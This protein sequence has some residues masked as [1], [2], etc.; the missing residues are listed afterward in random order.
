MH[1]KMKRLRQRIRRS[2]SKYI[3]LGG[4][5]SEQRMSPIYDNNH[6]WHGEWTEADLGRQSKGV[7]IKQTPL[8]K[9]KFA[10]VW[11]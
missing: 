9:P 8:S 6:R 2:F 3:A 4:T 1:E 5:E 7:Q 11:W 10:T